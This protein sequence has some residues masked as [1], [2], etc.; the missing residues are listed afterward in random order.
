VQYK[1]IGFITQMESV[2]CAVRTGSSNKAVCA[3]SLKGYS[4]AVD[5][6]TGLYRAVP[7]RVSLYHLDISLNIEQDRQHAYKVILWRLRPTTV[8]LEMQ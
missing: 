4:K 5:G 2:Y 8:A 1:M 3:S 6:D 7:L